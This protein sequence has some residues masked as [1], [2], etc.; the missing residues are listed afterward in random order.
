MKLYKI[1]FMTLLAISTLAV[2]PVFSLAQQLES[3]NGCAIHVEG[4]YG[5]A[6]QI[7]EMGCTPGFP[8]MFYNYAS[9]SKWNSILP[10]RIAALSACDMTKPITDNG[11]VGSK[12]Y[13]SVMCTYSGELRKIK[14]EKKH[15]KGWNW[16]LLD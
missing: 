4:D 16:E 13:Q 14:M 12:P 7:S 9:S 3:E 8:I 10:V 2:L 6:K 1:I 15:V 5:V 11:V